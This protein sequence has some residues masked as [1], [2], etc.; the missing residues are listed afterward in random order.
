M[1]CLGF[2][3]RLPQTFADPELD[4]TLDSF[5][6][7]AVDLLAERLASV[8]LYGSV[9][10]G[11]LAP[12]Y[13][14]LDFLAVT[15][16]ELDQRTLTS[17]VEL[18]R[19]LRG[20]RLGLLG[21][22]LEGAFLPRGM[23]DPGRSGTALWW[24]TSGE[25]YWQRNQL[26]W[27]VLH[28]I[29]QRGIVIWG[30]DIRPEIPAASEQD[31]L[32]DIAQACA[33]MRRNGCGGGL[34]SVDWLLTAARLIMW[35]REDGQLSSKSEAAD[36]GYMHARGA[37]KGLL[38]RAKQVRKN[39]VLAEEPET[40]AWLRSLSEPIQEACTELEYELARAS[41]PWR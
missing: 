17:L 12:G 18:R 32:Q 22:M 41:R 5:V 13:G 35:L 10:L 37:W 25:R 3:M 6:G 27:L 7:M 30:E 29:R 4:R 8:V 14:D 36:W 21:H 2:A 28:V 15:D 39:P 33:S 1:T 31:L 9:V 23:L 24:G 40:Q 19:P 26:G 20:G 34:H 11:D 38:P 16:C